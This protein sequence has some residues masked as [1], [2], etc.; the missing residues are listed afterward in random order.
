MHAYP[1]DE[2]DARTE[3][4]A[5]RFRVVVVDPIP[6]GPWTAFDLDDATAAEAWAWAERHKGDG[7]YALAVRQEHPDGGVALLWLTDP[8][9]VLTG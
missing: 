8:P 2:R 7:G 5:T 3:A 9:D 1:V 4:F 6:S